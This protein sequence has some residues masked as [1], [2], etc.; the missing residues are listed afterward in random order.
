MPRLFRA[1]RHYVLD[2][3]ELVSRVRDD[4]YVVAATGETLVKVARAGD[5]P[6]A[7]APGAGRRG[8]QALAKSIFLTR[9]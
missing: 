3:G 5:G 6:A 4:N 8:F 7:E 2:T 9:S 1:A